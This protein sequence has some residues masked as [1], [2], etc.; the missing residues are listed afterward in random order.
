MLC[1]DWGTAIKALGQR[2]NSELTAKR[3]VLWLVSGGSNIG[4]SV[5]IMAALPTELTASLTVMLVD[6]RY[7]PPEHA[8]SNW[9]QLLRAGF[10]HKSARLRP[11]LEAGQSFELALEHYRQLVSEEFAAAEVIVAQLGMGDDGHIAGILPDSSAA[12]EDQALVVSYEAGDFQRLTL[13]F[14]ALRNVTANYV[15][16]FGKNKRQA[17]TNLRDQ[18]ISPI[19]QPAQILKQ[20]SEVYIYNDQLGDR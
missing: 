16:A 4:A 6:E 10:D 2:L 8:D 19:D 9:A 1:D 14:P 18:T 3:R 7:G 12:R 15:L 17:L 5:Q 20:L 11:V 13:T